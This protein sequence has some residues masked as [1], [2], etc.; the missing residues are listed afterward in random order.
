[1]SSRFP[2]S[3]T[4]LPLRTIGFGVRETWIQIL[5]T[6]TDSCVT[7]ASELVSLSPGLLL[8]ICKW[9]RSV[10]AFPGGYESLMRY[11][12]WKLFSQGWLFPSS[13][14]CS[15]Y[16]SPSN[17]HNS[18]MP[19]PCPVL[20]LWKQ[21]WLSQHGGLLF[22]LLISG[23]PCAA[24]SEAQS[25]LITCPL[26]PSSQISGSCW[27]Y[28]GL[29][30]F[31]AMDHGNADLRTPPLSPYIFLYCQCTIVIRGSGLLTFIC[32][33]WGLSWGLNKYPITLPTIHNGEKSYLVLERL[34]TCICLPHWQP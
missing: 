21:F 12:I 9:H 5:S 11:Y 13:S 27:Q 4:G 10:A 18:L 30:G 24:S 1:M 32:P 22:L 7:L 16:P 6:A 2:E 8:P 29:F 28:S 34:P 14:F 25:P 31:T 20:H 23:D 33:Q 26:T 15:G 3:L 19:H 17:I